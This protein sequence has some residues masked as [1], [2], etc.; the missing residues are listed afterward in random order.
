[1][2]AARGAAKIQAQQG[3]LAQAAARR[4]VAAALHGNQRQ[5][6]FLTVFLIDQ[7][8]EDSF[9]LILGGNRSHQQRCTLTPSRSNSKAFRVTGQ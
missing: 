4:R 7:R 9:Q 3:M 5:L 1:M 2:G 8:Q 6:S